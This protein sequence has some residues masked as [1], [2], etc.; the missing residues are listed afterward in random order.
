MEMRIRKDRQDFGSLCG[1]FIP[2]FSSQRTPSLLTN[3][4]DPF[5]HWQ[6][7][8]PILQIFWCLSQMAGIFDG[9]GDA[10]GQNNDAVNVDAD[11]NIEKNNN[12]NKQKKVCQMTPNCQG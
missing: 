2:P 5:L 9:E 8:C 7:F 3:R 12:P 10:D 4:K 1:A 11:Q 6:M